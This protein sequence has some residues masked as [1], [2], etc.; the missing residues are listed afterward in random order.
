[1]INLYEVGGSIRDRLLGLEHNDID[2][3]AECENY[4]EMKRYVEGKLGMK[5]L[6]E[7]PEYGTLKA[8][9]EQKEKKNKSVD[10]SICRKDG[11]YSDG[12]RPDKIEITD[13]LTDLSRRDFTMNAIAI[14]QSLSVETQTQI[15]EQKEEIIDPFGGVRD[16]RLKIVR[17]VG[18]TKSKLMEDPLRLL[19]AL[20]FAV[21]KNMKL[22][23]EIYSVMKDP[24]FIERLSTCNLS[25]ERRTEEIR[26]MFSHDTVSSL[27]IFNT[28]PLTLQTI[29]LKD[30][31]LIPKIF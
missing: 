5:I 29:L 17:C 16:I 31:K 25:I 22:D 27:Q 18:D 28:L 7:K 12:R 23:E 20:R 4:E 8:I 2:Y 21:T 24:E 9:K 30:I 6:N 19:R 1:M 10:F 11:N 26:K 13:I 3:A 15:Q 14:L